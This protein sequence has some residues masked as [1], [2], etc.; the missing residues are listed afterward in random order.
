MSAA[1]GEDIVGMVSVGKPI[2]AFSPFI[3]NARNKLLLF[4][5]IAVIAFAVLLLLATVWLVR[6]FGFISDLWYAA[7]RGPRGSVRQAARRRRSCGPHRA[8]QRAR[9]G[10][11]AQLCRRVRDHADARAQE[12]PGGDPWRRGAAARATAGGRAH[13]LHRQHRGTDAACPGPDRPLARTVEPRAARCAAMRSTVALAPLAQGAADELGPVAQHKQVS[14]Q[15]D[16]GDDLVVDGEPFLLQRAL[17]NLVRNAIEFAPAGS[18]VELAARD[19]GRDLV[20]R[21]ATVAP[22][23]RPMRVRGC[24]RN[25]SRCRVRTPAARA[26]ASA[27]PSCAK[28][29]SCTAAAC[30]SKTTPDG[31]ATRHAAPAA[32]GAL[33]RPRG[34]RV[35]HAPCAP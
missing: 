1:A 30:A 35:P 19:D 17:A 24:S 29:R 6:P 34:T 22:A 28:S 9:R 31:G 27:S 26:P 23:C 8:R 14:L 10:R 20:S 15:L 3:V 2:A 33:S 12:P 21:C 13:A 16:V 5:A 7:T 32:R 4:G 25:S 11:R 18:V